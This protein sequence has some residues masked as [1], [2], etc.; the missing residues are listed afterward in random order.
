MLKPRSMHSCCILGDMLYAIAGLDNRGYTNSIE[1]VN[2]FQWTTQGAGT[3][4][5]REINFDEATF[6]PRQSP[7]VAAIDKENIVIVGGMPVFSEVSTFNVT[8]NTISSQKHPLKVMSLT[9]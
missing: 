1:V 3:V 6:K 4:Q 7:I 9:N 5:W 8:K 2:A